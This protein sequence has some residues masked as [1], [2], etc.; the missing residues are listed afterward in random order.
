MA[1]GCA[2]EELL[3][4]AVSRLVDRFQPLRIILFGSRARGQARPD[5]DVDLLVVLP[6][7]G[8]KHQTLVSMLRVLA[9]LPVPV[10]VIPTDPDELARRAC[11]VGTVLHSAVLEGK[12]IYERV[13]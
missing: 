12:V 6:H 3:S 10:D 13:G 1:D 8:N 7:V 11:V 5:S 4:T 2:S 9:D